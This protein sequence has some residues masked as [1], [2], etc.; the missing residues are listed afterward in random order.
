MALA[1][2]VHGMPRPQGVEGYSR[3]GWHPATLPPA[4][5]CTT[6]CSGAPSCP[7]PA[8]LHAAQHLCQGRD[9]LCDQ[10]QNGL[11]LLLHLERL[12]KAQH[13]GVA[14]HAQPLHAVPPRLQPRVALGGRG[15][16]PD[17]DG[18]AVGARG[19]A[20]VL[21]RPKVARQ[22]LAQ[23][24]GQAA[25][26]QAGE[27]REPAEHGAAAAGVQ[28]AGPAGRAQADKMAQRS[29]VGPRGRL[30]K[31]RPANPPAANRTAAAV[32]AVASSCRS[33]RWQ[34]LQWC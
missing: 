21:P 22:L 29:R 1:S 25:A 16:A 4:A 2:S 32:L 33:A 19:A 18:H 28:S 26:A 3:S 6:V 30:L 10:V 5:P 11:P 15:Q 17:G 7:P 24:K 9:R 13:A 31:G 20:V 34:L 8:H 14:R 23:L 27:R 12:P